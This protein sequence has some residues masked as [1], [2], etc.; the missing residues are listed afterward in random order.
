MQA[1]H[2][3]PGETADAVRVYLKPDVE[4]EPEPFEQGSLEEN[5]RLQKEY[6]ESITKYKVDVWALMN[7]PVIAKE[8]SGEGSVSTAIY[9]LGIEAAA[10]EYLSQ[11]VSE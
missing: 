6:R 7:D 5:L 3:G 4:L 2:L 1:W 11:K 8:Y 10:E 9:V